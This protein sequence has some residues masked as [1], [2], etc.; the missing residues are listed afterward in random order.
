MKPLEKKTI[1]TMEDYLYN[2]LKVSFEKKIK[3][4]LNKKK[5]KIQNTILNHLKKNCLYNTMC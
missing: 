2:G 3:S 4:R 5:I 1:Y